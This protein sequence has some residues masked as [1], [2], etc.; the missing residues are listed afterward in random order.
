MKYI[1]K[2]FL[3]IVFLTGFFSSCQ[4]TSGKNSSSLKINIVEEP[5]TLDPRK[6]RDLNTIALMKMLYE[7][8]TRIAKD[9][10]AELALAKDVIISK[11][12][13]HYVFN[14]RNARWTNGSFITSYD[15]AKSWKQ[16]LS[17]SF[18]S[19][20]AYQLYVVKGAKEAKEGKLSLDKI[21]VYAPNAETLIVDLENPCQIF[22]E[23]LSQPIFFPVSDSLKKDPNMFNGSGPFVIKKWQHLNNIVL[24]KNNAY[25]DANAVKLSNIT[26]YMVAAEA[27]LKMFETNELDWA[28]S[29]FSSI[30]LDALLKLQKEPTYYKQPFWATAFIRVNVKEMNEKMNSEENSL[31]LRQALFSA[32]DREALVKEV[33]HDCYEKAFSLVPRA[34]KMEEV[35]FDAKNKKTAQFS[36]KKL[37]LTF[38]NVGRNYL[39]AQVVQRQWEDLLKIKIELEPVETKVLNDRLK[40]GKYQLALGGWVADYNDPLNFLEV[41]KYKSNGTN[42]TF[43]ENKEFID[44]L[45]SA[46]VCVDFNER[47]KIINQAERILMMNM[48]VIPIY[49]LNLC[50]LKKDNIKDAYLSPL[51][52]IDF[53]WAYIE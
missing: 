23:L 17:P 33:L 53:K 6:A 20:M 3:L 25:W 42:N 30:P 45:D 15:I 52:L 31:E 1:C 26:L 7:G 41:F 47:K 36:D 49:H 11:D 40:S 32:L 39:I 12:Y 44:L 50:F 29:P 13:K 16:A 9:G 37:K 10:T 2:A 21:G 34:M 27:E 18:P 48:P 28:G 51:G 14:L 24:E 35:S 46:K 43:W 8:L 19:P 38:S 22:L 4:K 5:T